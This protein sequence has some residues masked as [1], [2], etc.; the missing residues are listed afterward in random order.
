MNTGN[1]STAYSAVLLGSM[2]LLACNDAPTSPELRTNSAA[3]VEHYWDVL[4][5]TRWNTRATGLLQSQPA[6]PNGQ[7]WASRMLTYLSLAQYRAV[8]DA[9]SPSARPDK[10]SVSAAVARASVVLLTHFYTQTPGYSR[11]TVPAALEQLLIADRSAPGWPGESQKS[12]EAGNTIGLAAGE[13]AW[14]QAQADGYNTASTA[15]NAMI[16]SRPVGAGYWV[17]VGSAVRSLWGVQP[18]FLDPDHD[19]M[20]SAPPPSFADL[21]TG[22]AFVLSTMT[23]GAT[24]VIH[25]H[26]SIALLWNR[27]PPNGAFTAGDWNRTAVDLIRS[28]HRTES[29]AAE[30][31]F[32]SNAAGFD[33][34]IDCF[35]TKYTYWTP[36]PAMLN[37]AI[38]PLFATPN[39]PSYPSGH[40]CISSAFGAVL[41]HAFP[42]NASATWLSDPVDEA[43]WSRVYAGIH[44][45]ADIEAGHG[46]GERAAA[47]ALKGT[48]D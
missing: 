42:D 23:S 32:L 8:R 45:V 41:E 36:R 38:L 7:A 14:S 26:D 35:V 12:I 31:L 15:F 16:A 33:A 19:Y 13:S 27:V 28:H 34:Q 30:I 1:R 46:V 40:S 44:Y 47:K 37:G 25:A 11:P 39:H 3:N 2:I 5:T 48:I 6:P 20:L 24:D 4:A 21:Q 43:G 17:L 9:S 29:Q 18:F 22:A 10:A